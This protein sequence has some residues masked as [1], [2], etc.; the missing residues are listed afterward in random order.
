VCKKNSFK[1]HQALFFKFAFIYVLVIVVDKNQCQFSIECSRVSCL[2]NTYYIL[3][4]CYIIYAFAV[5][6]DLVHFQWCCSY[7]VRARHT[8]GQPLQ[9]V[10]ILHMIGNTSWYGYI[11]S[12][13]ASN[14]LRSKLR[15]AQDK[16]FT[17]LILMWLVIHDSWLMTV[18]LQ[19]VCVCDHCCIYSSFIEH[20]HK[21]CLFVDMFGV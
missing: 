16:T 5:A 17:R 20:V 9:R 13:D 8:H 21:C 14:R 15:D 2:Y 7:V 19:C 11:I 4:T 12:L 6:I 10:P 3:L 18:W 1:A